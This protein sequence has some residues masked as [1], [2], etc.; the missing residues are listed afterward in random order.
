MRCKQC[1]VFKDIQ[2]FVQI[3]VFKFLKNASTSRVE[4]K[5]VTSH[6]TPNAARNKFFL[7]G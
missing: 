2:K 1:F 4:G 7:G 5:A 6:R 3:L